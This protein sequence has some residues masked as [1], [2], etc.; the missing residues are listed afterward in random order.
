MLW[1]LIG[2]AVIQL[3]WVPPRPANGSTGATDTSEPGEPSPALPGLPGSS[4]G[5][6]TAPSGGPVA[7]IVLT[8]KNIAFDA[9]TI[10]GPADV[11]FTLALVNDDAGTPHNVEF[12]GPDGQSVWKG[13]IF[14]GVDTRVYDVGPLPAAE[15][16]FQCSVHPTMAGTATLAH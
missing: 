15:Y 9:T 14:N 4:G 7:D 12:L 10:T 6:V 16:H 2:A 13:E 1:L 8:A 3:G 11:P 5:A